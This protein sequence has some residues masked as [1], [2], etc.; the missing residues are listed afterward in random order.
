MD[1]IQVDT[2]F[3]RHRVFA[4]IALLFIAGVIPLAVGFVVNHFFPDREW[5][6]VAF[7]SFIAG[8]GSLM[9]I[10][11]AIFILV[12]INDENRNY[13]LPLAYA[14]LSMG[15]LDGFHASTVPSPEFVWLHSSAKFAGG[16]FLAMIWLPK[17]FIQKLT[18][19][20]LPKLL[21]VMF[22]VTGAVSISY[23]EMLPAV[24][25]SGEF[26]LTPR[27]LNVIGGIS[28][29]AG[30]IYFV[31]RFYCSG[32]VILLLF[33]SV[34]LLFG[35]A[36]VTFESSTLW[37]TGWWMWHL[38][39]L[40]ACIVA[41]GYVAVSSVSEYRRTI[42]AERVA[43]VANQQLAASERQLKATNRML[44]ESEEFLDATGQMA[45]VG[46]WELDLETLD[47]RW[48][49]ETCRIHKVPLDYKPNLQEAINYYHPQDR[50]RIE[51]AV[52]QAIDEGKPYDIKLRLITA[53]GRQVWVQTNGKAEIKNGKTVKLSGTFQ[54][55]TERKEAEER[56]KSS[57]KEKEL[58]LKEI[59]HRTK[60]NF[61]VISSMLYLQ[62]EYTSSRKVSD[63]L[64]KCYGR[65][66][67]MAAVHEYLYKSE[68]F[69][70][71]DFAE[72]VRD[73]LVSLY[74][75][76]G[77]SEKTVAFQI[78]IDNVFLGLDMAVPCGLIINELISN[79]LKHAFGEL[80]K[81]DRRDA[82]ISVD[83][84]KTDDNKFILIVNDNGTGLAGDLNSMNGKTF[85]LYLIRN[86]VKQL[87][88]A[89]EFNT[90]N[91]TKFTIT[92]PYNVE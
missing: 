16:L 27:I 13:M 85:G 89:V 84:H 87:D 62:S 39:R 59:Y 3:K 11:I 73:L 67:S 12:R 69:T 54:D 50:P 83:M 53:N 19:K 49:K 65:I 44:R 22:V 7:H 17:R 71:I 64:D 43:E 41:L 1:I 51:Q 66:K 6:Y 48:T 8:F 15:I 30:G 82:K 80:K 5:D 14:M 21:A 36:G 92:F 4:I 33:S 74:H 88:G 10:T 26:T 61:Q 40:A 9:S 68:D 28:F 90:D 37:G 78:N 81:C 32:D 55:I 77:I 20:W 91:G 23:P 24:L 70:N 76:Y 31:I 57:L 58:L 2:F 29:L 34:C 60:N 35:A 47:V 79:S 52:Q 56:I 18:A 86:L 25:S 45:K 46:G 72:Y 42:R 63:I 75:S 38:M